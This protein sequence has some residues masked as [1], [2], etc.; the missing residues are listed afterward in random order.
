MAQAGTLPGPAGFRIEREGFS[1]KASQASMF[2]AATEK[3][4]SIGFFLVPKFSMMAF[5]SAIEPLRSANR[6]AGTELYRWTLY[7][8]DGQPVTASNG[9]AVMPHALIRKSGRL[10]MVIVCSGLDVE[11][12]DDRAVFAWLRKLATDGSDI[13]A[14]SNGAHILARAGLLEGRKCALH[15]EN[16]ASFTELFPNVTVTD[17]IFVVDGNRFTCSGGTAALD[18]MLNMIKAQHGHDLAAAVSEQFIHGPI[19]DQH[20][21]QRTEL[22]TRLGVAHP[23]L[24]AAIAAM[25]S[26]L[27]TPL[28]RSTIAKQVKLSARQLERL[29]RNYLD[30]T[31][32]HYYLEVRLSRARQL[33]LQTSESILNVALGCGFVSASHFSKCFRAR[34]GMT[35]REARRRL[36][37]PHARPAVETRRVLALPQ[38]RRVAVKR[39]RR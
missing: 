16:V 30:C 37:S 28:A 31:P 22:R 35:P 19:R 14:L 24:L 17:D 12:F 13:G 36:E 38:P 33:L 25:E 20:D 3:P 9:I 11:E 1:L 15:W 8:R 18:M 29:F 4:L 21:R 34:Y 27:G 23:K 2:G 10:P 39:V 26:N 5:A 32:T 6:L 7:S